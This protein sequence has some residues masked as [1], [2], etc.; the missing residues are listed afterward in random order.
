MRHVARAFLLAETAH[1][2][3]ADLTC[4][5]DPSDVKGPLGMFH[6]PQC[7]E[8]VMAGQPHPDYTILDKE[9]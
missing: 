7:G 2:L 6:C 3:N 1:T 5:F 9:T 4:D 8:M